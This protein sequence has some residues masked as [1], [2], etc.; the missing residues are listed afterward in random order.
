M[1]KINSGVLGKY[2]LT[3]WIY[4]TIKMICGNILYSEWFDYIFL[5][6]SKIIVTNKYLP[7]IINIWYYILP[8]AYARWWGHFLHIF[9]NCNQMQ[10]S[11][12]CR[13]NSL[14]LLEYLVITT[15]HVIYHDLY[16][17]ESNYVAFSYIK[18]YILWTLFQFRKFDVVHIMLILCHIIFIN[19]DYHEENFFRK[20]YFG[21]KEVRM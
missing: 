1:C 14:S 15:W 17:K 20:A 18:I 19:S 2:L 16:E 4:I 3:Y 13:L 8:P 6:K 11:Y 9:I 21:Y 7:E 5:D 10:L 12:T